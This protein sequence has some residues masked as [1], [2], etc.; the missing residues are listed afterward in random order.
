MSAKDY[1]WEKKGEGDAQTRELEALLGGQKFKGMSFPEEQ[2]ATT[3]RPFVLGLVAALAAVAVLGVWLRAPEAGPQAVVLVREGAVERSA[4]PG[5]WIDT[6]PQAS[7]TLTLPQKIGTVEVR[8]GSRV[9]VQRLSAN[10]QRL[11]LERGQLHAVVTAPP[12]LFVVDTPSATAVDLG[13][14]YTLEVGADGASRL[15]VLTG[16]VLLEGGGKETAVLDGMW[17]VSRKNEA[18]S[19]AFDALSSPAFVAAV[20]QLDPSDEATLDVMLT[21]AERRDGV[22]LFQL[23]SRVDEARRAKVEARLSELVPR[24]A[25]GGDEAWFARCDDARVR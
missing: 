17:A 14:E 8:G 24:P 9:R 10:E 25:T 13:C 3:R 22:T 23:R 6:R 15:D 11:E 7:A 2:R 21:K 18:P 19:V 4:V 1:L 5:E 12:R 16:E 20:R